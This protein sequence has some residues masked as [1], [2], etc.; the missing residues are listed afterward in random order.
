MQ[1]PPTFQLLT[2][3]EAAALARVHPVTLSR[4]IREGR[5]PAVTTLGDKRLFQA[6]ALRAWIDA[7]TTGAPS[8]PVAA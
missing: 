5:G 2:T 6:S 7:R 3:R 4:L 8:V 1:N